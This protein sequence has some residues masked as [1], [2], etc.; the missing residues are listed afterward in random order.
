MPKLS[1]TVFKNKRPVSTSGTS[2]KYSSKRTTTTC[3]SWRS[4][5]LLIWLQVLSNFTLSLDNLLACISFPVAGS[6][7]NCSTNSSKRSRL[8][9]THFFGS[10]FRM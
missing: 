6:R 2:F 3:F 4:R 10:W 7:W 9:S 1:A 8:S 5:P